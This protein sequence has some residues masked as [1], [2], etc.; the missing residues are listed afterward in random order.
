MLEFAFA[1]IGT[2]MTTAKV[3]TEDQ[4]HFKVRKIVDA[5]RARVRQTP[6]LAPETTRGKAIL[7]FADRAIQIGEACFRI[8]DLQTPLFLL[9]RALCEDLLL[10]FW[11]S[12]SEVNAVSY[13]TAARSEASRVLRTS[14]RG[15]RARI[16]DKKTGSD[17]TAGFL[18]QLEPFI[19]ERQRLGEIACRSG[20]GKVYDIIYRHNSLEVHG[21]TFGLTESYSPETVAVALSAISAFL[22]AILNIVNAGENPLAAADVLKILN[23]QNLEEGGALAD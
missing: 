6:Y 4:Y 5:L 19:V 21:N 1:G 10:M 3:L 9:S 23:I 7:Y 20:L 14:L 17:V 12:Q 11:A 2:R 22:T 15:K 13:L 18:P 8:R 16:L